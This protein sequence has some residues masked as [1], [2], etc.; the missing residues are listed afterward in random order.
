MTGKKTKKK[1]KIDIH[2]LYNSKKKR[3]K[4]RLKLKIKSMIF[5]KMEN[6]KK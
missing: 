5:L 4:K 6:V 3:R 2:H 1:G